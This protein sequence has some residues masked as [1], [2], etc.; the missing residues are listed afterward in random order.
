[1]DQKI[2]GLLTTL[3]PELLV[4]LVWSLCVLQ[5]V[6]VPYLQS[7][8]GP[9]FHEH[10]LHKGKYLFQV[11]VSSVPRTEVYWGRGGCWLQGC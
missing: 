1:M 5:Q 10:L 9:A 4:D 2:S 3:S 6:K 7:V 11:S 8:L